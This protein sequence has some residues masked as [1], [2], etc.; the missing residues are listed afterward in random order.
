MILHRVEPRPDSS[1][2]LTVTTVGSPEIF[3]GSIKTASSLRI[4]IFVLEPMNQQQFNGRPNRGKKS[5]GKRKKKRIIYMKKE[6]KLINFFLFL[7]VYYW[8]V[9]VL[10]GTYVSSHTHVRRKFKAGLG[11]EHVPF[12]E[13]SI[14]CS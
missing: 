5:R 2:Q 13:T 14:F 10:S 4:P 12:Y 11:N 6:K 8:V 9:V 1:G 3:P 7:Y